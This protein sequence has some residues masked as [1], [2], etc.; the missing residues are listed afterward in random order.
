M[1]LGLTY[2]LQEDPADERQA[3][4]DPPRTVD[5]L[6]SA[7][8]ALGHEVVRLGGAEALLAAPWRLRDVG[9]IFNIA[10]GAFG[11]CREAWVPMLLEQ[12]RV[13][14]VGSGSTTLALGLDKVMSKRLAR[15]S[16]I[17]TPAWAVVE[18]GQRLERL[19]ELSFP[20]IVKPREEGSGRG[21]DRHAV[22]HTFAELAERV[23][24]VT[25]HYRQP[26]LVEQFIPFGE[27]TVFMIGNRPPQA[28]P[29]IQRPLDPATRLA[30][31]V[32]GPGA[33]WLSP[34]ELTP[35]L[36]EEARRVALTM[37]Q[38]LRCRDMAR[39]DLRVD[40]RG[41]V[42]FLEINPL[43][44]FDPEGSLGLLAEYLGTAY[45]RLVGQI[46]DAAVARLGGPEAVRLARES[47]RARRGAHGHV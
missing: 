29:A 28:L 23:A 13:P 8:R 44:S 25:A 31:H 4:F 36:D 43:P 46:L 22:V 30:C 17:R 16:G 20:L 26:C 14:F 27:L 18:P 10:E 19:R 3:E 33:A 40:E 15:A 42:Y 1:H 47:G 21:I 38:A 37:F 12:W 32:A 35:E 6:A 34:L 41:R 2:D 7:L 11:R 45:E 39:V 24:W 9:L 5:A